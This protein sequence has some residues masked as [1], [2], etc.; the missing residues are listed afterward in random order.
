MN[1]DRPVIAQ[2]LH[3]LYLA[4]AEVLS[5]DLARNLSDRFRFV[6][7][8][9]DAIGLL[10][11][12]LIAEGFEVLNLKRHPGID[13]SVAR[14]MG[15]LV[16]G[17]R[18]ALLHAHQYTPFFYAAAGRRLMRTPILFTEHG[19]HYPDQRKI[20]RVLANKLLLR[21]CDRV[22]SVGRFVKQSLVDYEGFPAHRIET[23]YNGVDIDR[24]DWKGNQELRGAAR[25]ALELPPDQQVVLQVARFHPVKDHQL[26]VRAFA[27]VV[28]KNKRAV[29][30]LAGA[31]AGREAIEDLVQ[32]L[33]I[34]DH[35]RFL[36]VQSD[37]PQI[38]AAADVFM[39]SSL[40]EGIS[41]TLLEAMASGLPVAATD[42]GGNGEVVVE[43]KTGVLS[44]RGNAEM[45]S[46]NLMALLDNVNMRI[47]MGQAAQQ[48]VR[49]CFAQEQMHSRYATLY[50]EMLGNHVTR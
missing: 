30:L 32:A 43:G 20:R 26:A 44:P 13:W 17:R 9:L 33:G 45:L 12:Q 21:R 5:A 6:F 35:V 31:G 47:S 50:Q 19:R 7:I 29:L 36:G 10:G 3:R 23:V 37:I 46:K 2:V 41:V 34:N 25:R 27:R 39:L 8:C 40:S 24:F 42:V 18:I 11:D 28:S 22:T 15:N 14:C 1:D 49:K 38:M 4:G 48:R 16:R